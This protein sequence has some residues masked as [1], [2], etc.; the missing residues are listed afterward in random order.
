MQAQIWLN[1][2]RAE[3]LVDLLEDNFRMGG[4]VGAG[5]GADFAVYIREIFG[6]G[7]QPEMI[8]GERCTK[9]PNL[10]GAIP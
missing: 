3:L 10:K 1:R 5:D 6:M 2:D 8:Y 4:K 9:R 7:K